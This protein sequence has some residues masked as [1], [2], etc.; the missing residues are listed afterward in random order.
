MN[1]Y[2]KKIFSVFLVLILL[3]PTI[4]KFEHQHVKFTCF[5]KSEKHFH[6]YQEQ[7][8]VCNFEFSLFITEKNTV[9]SVKVENF[10]SYCNSYTSFHCSNF[11]KYSFLLR[12]P[13]ISANVV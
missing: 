12:A 5:T 3:V 13:P 11:T 8:N 4:V 6:T 2:L 1:E 10:Y 9:V 7:C